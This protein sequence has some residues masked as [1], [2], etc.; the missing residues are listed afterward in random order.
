[1]LTKTNLATQYKK[2]TICGIFVDLVPVSKKYVKDIVALRNTNRARYFLNQQY[3]LTEEMQLKWMEEYEKRDNDLY[4]CILDKKGE[5]LGTYRLYD[6]IFE[7]RTAESGSSNLRE[8]RALEAPYLLEAMVTV[9]KLAFNE[10]KLEKILTS[11]RH[12][13]AKVL[14]SDKR[15]GFSEI[16]LT[17]NNGVEY[18]VLELDKEKF[19]KNG[20][21]LEKI[22]NHWKNRS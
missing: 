8:D 19:M 5:F 9:Y 13:N 11:V 20:P 18:I 3:L 4:W 21:I 22:I 12:D 15:M 17:K 2:Q 10:L 16:G 7:T 1:M 14:S 6:I